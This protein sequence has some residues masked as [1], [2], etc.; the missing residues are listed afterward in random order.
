MYAAVRRP[1]QQ[2]SL[3]WLARRHML[4]AVSRQ[5]RGLRVSGSLRRDDDAPDRPSEEAP[6]P[7]AP[8]PA[9]D[10][11]KSFEDMF[12]S[13]ARQKPLKATARTA[14]AWAI[15]DFGFG[16]GEAAFAQEP[17]KSYSTRKKHARRAAR[18]TATDPPAQAARDPETKWFMPE[19]K[20]N[21]SHAV[22]DSP[23]PAAETETAQP[24]SP[25][26]TTEWLDD[27]ALH[28]T[29]RA[30]RPEP[31][32]EIH[33]RRRPPR[34]QPSRRRDDSRPRQFRPRERPPRAQRSQKPLEEMLQKMS[35][36]G[37]MF[38]AR[39]VPLQPAGT[40][41]ASEAE[42]NVSADGDAAVE[43]AAPAESDAAP[44]D[45]SPSSP[46]APTAA[47]AVT[48]DPIA[49]LADIPRHIQ[50]DNSSTHSIRFRS[51]TQRV[52]IS[53]EPLD[54]P[55]LGELG[56]AIVMRASRPP[57][58]IAYDTEE[59]AAAGALDAT[60]IEAMAQDRVL[61]TAS[62][63]VANIDELR[64]A[65]NIVQYDDF[66]RLR[67][68]LEGSLTA[69]NLQDYL[70]HYGT[71][72]VLNPGTDYRDPEDVSYNWISGP[73]TWIPQTLLVAKDFKRKEVLVLNLLLRQWKLKIQEEEFGRGSISVKMASHAVELL[74]SPQTNMLSLL[75]RRY[76]GVG[77]TIRI[78][79][80][81][82]TLAISASHALCM[83]LL[84]KI[85][86]LVT[87]MRGG[88]IPL[89]LFGNRRLTEAQVK[90]LARITT[91]W[92]RQSPEDAKNP[93][94][95]VSWVED[96]VPMPAIESIKHV[97]TRLM[98]S[99]LVPATDSTTVAIV[100][101]PTAETMLVQD[102]TNPKNRSW[103]NRMGQWMR[104]AAP[105]S[106]SPSSSS[107][108]TSPP[109]AAEPSAAEPSAAEPSAAEPSAA[110]LSTTE[111]SPTEAAAT[112]DSPLLPPLPA[113]LTNILKWPLAAATPPPPAPSPLGWS[114][115]TTRT[116]AV[117][118]H[119]LHNKPASTDTSCIAQPSSASLTA[120]FLAPAMPHISCLAQ[121]PTDRSAQAPSE[122]HTLVLHFVASPQSL[123][124]SSAS[125]STPR[126]ELHISVPPTATSITW[127]NSAKRLV[128]IRAAHRAHM[129]LPAA[130]VDVQLT[131]QRVQTL[132]ASV[133][134]EHAALRRFVDESILDVVEGTL[135]TPPAVNVAVPLGGETD[136]DA[137]ADAAEL[138]FL[139][140]GL[141]MRETFSAAF[142]GHRL[143]HSSIEAGYHGGQRAEL[144]LDP[145]AGA[146][147]PM[148]GLDATIGS[149][150][151]ADV[152]VDAAFTQDYLR[153]VHAVANGHYFPWHQKLERFT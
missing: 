85:D 70:D 42:P 4:Q 23:D 135:R 50:V 11:F 18:Q 81:S 17:R 30:E 84:R 35:A 105:S 86:E 40:K 91:T 145:V 78:D 102:H 38:D 43:S 75:K 120:A 88:S 101:P 41:E 137:D 147:L 19:Y 152:D 54:K 36:D 46:A 29:H 134:V 141:E 142:H 143:S 127:L 51:P 67:D 1:A 150:T 74:L 97:V 149:S 71:S 7:P 87:R 32:T 95:D 16:P 140:T 37:L 132:A 6:S 31:G 5:T 57:K 26:T 123:P 118:G 79:P 20:E 148:G 68:E 14:E 113:E 15:E 106:T 128:Y 121:I 83:T 56:Q 112:A 108:E 27:D 131:Q 47:A 21:P 60:A 138:Q 144:A 153:A 58:P 77:D 24:V 8:A 130:A 48:A 2:A 52:K 53:S 116:S 69:E 55:I 117:F 80:A 13:V 139:F 125:A 104:L 115:I 44:S 76:L 92:I 62:E 103:K 3:Q 65:A 34:H 64:P 126:L 66:V 45:P 63:L 25:P 98:H 61:P 133:L 49:A 119:V 124:P 59:V 114:P 100:P 136:A 73:V 99:A 28:T 94:V 33:D 72:R 22:E 129:L 151:D 109:S 9:S 93:S 10:N 111:P 89:A 39:G 122:T 12:T 96:I 146:V 82:S 107:A 90:E 110:E